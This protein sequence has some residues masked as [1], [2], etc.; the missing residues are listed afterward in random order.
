MNTGN[1]R[2][3]LAGATA[4]LCLAGAALAQNAQDI[5]VGFNSDISA[6]PSAIVGQSGLAAIQAAIEDVNAAGG[7]L[8]RKLTVVV[9][10]DTGLPPKAIQNAVELINN[11]NVVAM[12]GASNSGNVMAWKS[13]VNRAKIPAII[14]L[15]TATDITKP[16]TPGQPNFMFR[17][18]MVDRYNI[19]G[20]LAYVSKNPQSNKVGYLTETT[21]Y[22]QG[23]LKDL[24]ELAP[25]YGI[26]PVAMEKFGVAD[27]DMSSQLN[28]LRAAG[29]D[30]LII[31]AQT[32]PMIQIFRSMEKINYFPLSLTSWV[33]DQRA[34]GEAAGPVLSEK[35][36]LIRTI[37][38]GAMRPPLARLYQRVVG[39]TTLDDPTIGQAAHSY[40]A[41]MLLVAAI[42][43]A[44]STDGEAIR[45]A[46]E[47][48]QTP[49][50]GLMKTYVQ[51]FSADQHEA[52][53]ASDYHWVR[54]KAGRV[55]A[56]TDAVIESLQ[57]SD[58]QQ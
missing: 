57:A 22:G 40:D 36:L 29:V 16:M 13:H 31:W 24:M 12:F 45:Q 51:P 21:G 19:S 43:Q 26:T 15:A 58:F 49:H 55:E 32:T 37:P 30:T 7:V 17:V 2:T 39:K 28:K 53:L 44:G 41:L 11:E 8:G 5:K 20:L 48:L 47:N 27:A 54:W 14:S 38:G 4:A 25:K 3:R 18:S 6:S 52:L 50:D 23:A 34:F 9:R 46:L 33:A 10:D 1:I 42:R 56:Y 35:P